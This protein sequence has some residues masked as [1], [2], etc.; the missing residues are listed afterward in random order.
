MQSLA[1]GKIYKYIAHN[2]Q[3]YALHCKLA[4]PSICTALSNITIYT[5]QYLP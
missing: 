3:D 5:T 4:G 1:I 2:T